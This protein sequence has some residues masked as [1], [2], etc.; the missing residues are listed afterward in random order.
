MSQSDRNS[1]RENKPRGNEPSFNWR[2]IILIA[3]AFALI[4]LAVVFRGGGYNY[5]EDVP[6]NRFLELLDNKQLVNDKNSPLT[7][8]VEEGRPTQSLVG[9][10]NKQGVGP[11]QGPVRFKTTI[12]LNFTSNLQE[13]MAA[14]GI[15]PAIKTESNVVA[16]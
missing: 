4:A 2:G 5:V 1:Q 15:Q 16:Q 7:L 11:A 14:A 8:V 9:L 3:I 10:Y 6:Y 13:K 12:Y